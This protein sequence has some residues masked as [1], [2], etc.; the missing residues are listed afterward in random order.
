MSLVSPYDYEDR[1]LLS[2]IYCPLQLVSLFKHFLNHRRFIISI[3]EE[4][5][6]QN[7]TLICSCRD[8]IMFNKELLRRVNVQ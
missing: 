8:N 2:G 6:N 7:C 5:C 4:K 1:I 3:L